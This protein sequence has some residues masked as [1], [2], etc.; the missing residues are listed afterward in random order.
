MDQYT[1][2][3]FKDND[4]LSPE[5]LVIKR[6]KL[7]E[8]IEELEEEYRAAQSYQKNDIGNDQKFL[9]DELEYVEFLI[10]SIIPKRSR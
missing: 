1:K 10:S 7:I 2:N 3:R 6:K 9:E 4:D 8:K 5:E